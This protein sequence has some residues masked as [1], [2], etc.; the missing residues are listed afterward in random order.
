MPDPRICSD[1]WRQ[2]PVELRFPVV[3]EKVVKR[4]GAGDQGRRAWSRCC[5]STMQV[6]QDTH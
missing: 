6:V 3:L 5:P 1:R 2:D 4:V